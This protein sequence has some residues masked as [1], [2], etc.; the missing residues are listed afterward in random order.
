VLTNWRRLDRRLRRWIGGYCSDETEV[1]PY[2]SRRGHPRCSFLR[3]WPRCLTASTPHGEPSRRDCSLPAEL[4]GAIWARP[5]AETR[6]SPSREGL[7]AEEHWDWINGCRRRRR[8][9]AG[10][11]GSRR[12]RWGRGSECIFFISS[13]VGDAGVRA[14]RRGSVLISGLSA[15]CPVWVGCALSLLHI[16]KKVLPSNF[17]FWWF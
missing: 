12:R 9:E 17:H 8:C 3:R 15:V 6:G 5:E 10:E 14:S 16:R 4:D 13:V 7:A 11:P 2:Y 1:A